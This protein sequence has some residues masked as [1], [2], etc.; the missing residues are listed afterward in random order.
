MATRPLR[1]DERILAAANHVASIFFP[2][3][4]PLVF[5]A[6]GLVASKYVAYHA[7][8]ALLEAI[9]LKA[10]T[11]L[12]GIVSLILTIGK[13]KELID[14]NGASFSWDLVWQAALKFVVLWALFFVAEAVTAVRSLFQAR[15]AYRGKVNRKV[16]ERFG[17]RYGLEL[18]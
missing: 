10:A 9:V 8:V 5:W 4:G 1:Q 16:A 12:V 11:V 14:T 6:V 18:Q 2:F 15:D 3:V 13:L 7:R 17:A